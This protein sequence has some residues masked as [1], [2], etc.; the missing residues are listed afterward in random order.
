MYKAVILLLLSFICSCCFSQDETF[1]FS[2][3]KE[4]DGL[5]NNVVNCMIKDRQGYFW[6]GT[7]NGFNRFDGANFYT[8]KI[9]K[10]KNT[11]VNEVVHGLCEDSEGKI[12]GI[13]NSEIFSYDLSKD[14]FVNYEC[15]SL[16][17]PTGFTNIL[18]DHSG[19]IWATSLVSLYKYNAAADIFELAMNT[20]SSEDSVMQCSISKNGLA[21]DTKKNALWLTTASG[22][23]CYHVKSKTTSNSK[24]ENGNPLFAKRF[25][26]ALHRSASG[27]YWFFDNTQKRI[28]QFD[29]ATHKEL[30]QIDI[31]SVMP[32]ANIATLFEDNSKRL[33][34]SSWNYKLLVV[35]VSSNNKMQ[36]LYHREDD[37]RT[38]SGDFF[39][40]AFQDANNTI[41]LG[42]VAGISRCNLEKNI[43]KE[44]RLGNS[45]TELKNTAIRLAVEDPWD[46]SFWIVSWEGQLIHYTLSKGDYQTVALNKAI[47]GKSGALPDYVYAIH[48]I[49][50][51]IVLTTSTGSWQLK[52]GESRLRP[53]DILPPGYTDFFCKEIVTDGDS[54]IYYNNTKELLYWNRK[55]NSIKSIFKYS[56]ASKKLLYG[57]HV[58]AAHR[59]WI[60]TT[61]TLV[62]EVTAKG[63]QP[64]LLVK[65][66]QKMAG[67]ISS[68]RSDRHNNLWVLNAGI[69]R[70]N[71]VQKKSQ[72]WNQ[73][74]GLPGNRIGAIL[75]D[76]TGRLWSMLYNNVSVF[77]P[78]ANT[79]YNFKIPYSENNLRYSTHLSQLANGHILGI[80]YNELVEFYPE[81][82]LA[83]PVLEKPLISLFKTKAREISV[84]DGSISGLN[85]DENTISIRFGCLI[86]NGVFPY[87]MEYKLEGGNN[88]WTGAE[89]H[90]ELI[91]TNL[92]PGKYTFKVRA[93][94]KNNAWQSDE[95][96]LSFVIKTPFYRTAWFIIAMLLLVVTS[97][98]VFYRYRLSQKEKLMLLETKAQSL[99]KE[100]ALVMYENLKQH[101]NPHFLFN[102]LTSLS[103]L[104]RLDQHMAG[105]FLDKMSKVYRYILKNRDNEVMPI[106]EELKFVQLYIGLQKTRFEEGLQ[107]I[108]NIDEEHYH[109]KI[110]P[111]T[112]QNLVE[113]AI[114]HNTADEASPL[115]I[116]LFVEQDYLVVRNNLQKKKFV[117]TS[118]R[119]GLANMQSLYRYLST[120]PM[121][122]IE[123]EHYFIVKI[124]L[125]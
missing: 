48:F 93:K 87:E 43:Y 57:L 121:E 55:I 32:D 9:R 26:A 11:L 80:I 67:I 47:A 77:I 31:V 30:R 3:L 85:T 72:F 61:D 42:T 125:L 74:D 56:D 5:S 100:K 1:V 114:K 88:N 50:D 89:G 101:L 53:F 7:Y 39:W 119:Q 71:V 108:I 60:A 51:K 81:R 116:E 122:I 18:Y 13:T 35:D 65:G 54:V 113:N 115:T 106:S 4:S 2:H 79:F 58:N 111:V 69:Y 37:N 63:I 104:I 20:T 105:N 112:L 34:L 64:V 117:E 41:W 6:I 22:L 96:E 103:S 95:T 28:I 46:K 36:Q 98:Y 120:R 33:W 59:I 23:I 12:W 49:D 76:T 92:A 73:T 25:T 38:I 84:F 97:A 82:L 16:G 124:P 86:D 15:K 110:A 68:L 62:A 45:I 21:E 10:G 109:R 118:N 94:G 91:F 24:T 66:E 123:N 99:E 90:E 8:Y 14:K 70:Y 83:S 75:P 40:T 17:K 107:V 78:D 44:Y 52:R 27:N 19:N 29:P 102:S